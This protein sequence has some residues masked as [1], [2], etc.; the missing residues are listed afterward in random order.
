MS[1]EKCRQKV[2]TVLLLATPRDSHP[3][4]PLPR[5]T[6]DRLVKVMIELCN[7]SGG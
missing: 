6:L 4:S 1:I 3:L 2:K 7:A 5:S